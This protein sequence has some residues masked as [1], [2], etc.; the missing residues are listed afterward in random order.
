LHY[1][2]LIGEAIGA[3]DLTRLFILQIINIV[4][5][6]LNQ[7]AFEKTSSKPLSA[8]WHSEDELEA[9]TVVAAWLIWQVDYTFYCLGFYY[10]LHGLWNWLRWLSMLLPSSSWLDHIIILFLVLLHILPLLLSYLLIFSPYS[11]HHFWRDGPAS[12]CRSRHR[13]QPSVL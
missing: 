12:A 2:I 8:L 10:F 11:V 4:I 9:V 1:I 13:N 6:N 3:F 5:H 7:I